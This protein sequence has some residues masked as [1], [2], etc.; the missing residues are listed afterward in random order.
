MPQECTGMRIH[1]QIRIRDLPVFFEDIGHDGV[2]GVDDMEYSSS[3]GICFKQTHIG[4]CTADR[5]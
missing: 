4:T 1:A 3:F 5:F 2:N